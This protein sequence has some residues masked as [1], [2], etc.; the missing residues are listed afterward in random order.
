[1]GRDD[2]S[3][4]ELKYCECCGGLWLRRENSKDVYCAYC[5]PQMADIAHGKKKQPVRARM[6]V[7]VGG[8]VCA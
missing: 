3:K 8:A 2:V 6:N 5:A 7:I 1:M 4:I